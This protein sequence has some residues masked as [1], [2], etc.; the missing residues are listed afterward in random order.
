VPVYVHALTDAPVMPWTEDDGRR[1]E[2]MEIEGVFVVAERRNDRPPVSEAELQRQHSIVTR[3][4]DAVP[5]VIPA[6]FGALAD[7][8]ELASILRQRRDRIRASLDHVRDNVQMTLRIAGPVAPSAPGPPGSGR[9]YLQR[10]SGALQPPI[11][12][13]AESTLREL[14]AYILDERRQ[15][16]ERGIVTVYHLI[17]R[18]DVKEYRDTVTSLAVPGIAMSGPF[19]AFAF[20]PELIE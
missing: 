14:R 13:H 11:P 10:R 1:I 15:A 5:A 18:A 2:T 9:E 16:G 4:A 17:R 19:A 12:P 3:V 20:A 8:A 6:R 7:E